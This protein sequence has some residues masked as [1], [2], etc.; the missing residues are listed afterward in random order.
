MMRLWRW[1]AASGRTARSI[2]VSNCIGHVEAELFC[3]L[4]GDALCP[5]SGIGM[6]YDRDK[7]RYR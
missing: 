1:P 2:E 7:A 6:R 5:V 3:R 4:V